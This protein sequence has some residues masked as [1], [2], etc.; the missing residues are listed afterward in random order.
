MA[1]LGE[2][3]AAYIRDHQARAHQEHD[4]FAS[5][6]SLR[7]AVRLAAL[8]QDCCGKR[9]SHQ[10]R[11]PHGVLLRCQRRL[12]DHIREIR[13]CRTFDQLH[14][15]IVRALRGVRGA[16]ELYY[17]DTAERI[18]AKLGIPPTR[19]YLH[20]G[21]R[22]GARTLGINGSRATIEVGELPHELRTLAPEELESLLC[23]Y[24][25]QLAG[26]PLRDISGCGLKRR[27][28]TC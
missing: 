20:A 5:Q 10:R 6:P 25:D 12:L 3:V 17:Y 9:L 21:T 18:S 2:I 16:G 11:I 22:A 19:I 13:T 7:E 8:A 15:T 4:W 14:E 27:R 24:R 1:N 28:P 26:A 23:L